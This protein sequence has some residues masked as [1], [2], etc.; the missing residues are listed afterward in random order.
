MCLSLEAPL[1]PHT[2]NMRIIKCFSKLGQTVCVYPLTT[3]IVSHRALYKAYKKA[4]E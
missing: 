3:Y 4:V 1:T 2:S